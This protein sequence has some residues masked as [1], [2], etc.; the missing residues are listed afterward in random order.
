MGKRVLGLGRFHCSSR[1]CY[2]LPAGSSPIPPI[3]RPPALHLWWVGWMV[4]LNQFGVTSPTMTWWKLWTFSQEKEN[5]QH[6]CTA[7]RGLWNKGNL[8]QSPHWR[9][10]DDL[11][12]LSKLTSFICP[13]WRP[14][15]EEGKRWACAKLSPSPEEQPVP[16]TPLLGL[17]RINLWERK[18]MMPVG[19]RPLG[20]ARCWTY[21]TFFSETTNISRL[22]NRFSFFLMWAWICPYNS[23]SLNILITSIFIA[24]SFMWSTT[25]VLLTSH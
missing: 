11:L 25:L 21:F 7:L 2:L 22:W 5:T 20:T 1:L 3:R 10:L 17:I 18:A 23:C 14:P 9:T 16:V 8:L 13:R 4:D 24:K 6:L 19:K 12:A 15:L